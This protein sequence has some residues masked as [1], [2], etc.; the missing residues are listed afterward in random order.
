MG[1]NAINP[2]IIAQHAL[3][4]S[5]LSAKDFKIIMEN[6]MRNRNCTADII[7][8]CYDSLTADVVK[9]LKKSLGKAEPKK[10]QKGMH[11]FMEVCASNGLAIDSGERGT[12]FV[13]ARTVLD[14]NGY[15]KTGD[16]LNASRAYNMD[17]KFLRLYTALAQELNDEKKAALVAAEAEQKQKEE[18]ENVNVNGMDI[19]SEK[20]V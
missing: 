4:H 1:S 18:A 13:F 2:P 12:Y 10:T 19:D 20:V 16:V 9:K 3:G 8:Q 5:G 6:V 14:T 17:A 7:K 11:L 15:F